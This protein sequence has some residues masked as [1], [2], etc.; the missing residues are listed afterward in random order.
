V[1]INFL[2]PL[3]STSFQSLL[4]LSFL[5]GAKHGFDADH[6]VAID[7]LTRIQSSANRRNCGALFSLGHGLVVLFAAFVLAA[8][9]AVWV[10]PQWL[11]GWALVVSTSLLIMLGGLNVWMLFSTPVD[12]PVSL[13]S[14]RLWAVGQFR[15]AAKLGPVAIGALMALSFDTLT[16]ALIFASNPAESPLLG[17]VLLGA[18]FTLG[19]TSSDGINGLLMARL[20]QRADTAAIAAS[21]LICAA[22]AL[23]CFLVGG[24]GLIRLMSIDGF[25]HLEEITSAYPWLLSTGVCAV[26]LLAYIAGL[27]KAKSPSRTVQ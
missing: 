4:L 11:S 15:F 20:M 6:L 25:S 24:L 3:N 18:V 9:G 27:R 2:S 5:L 10:V 12:K 8:L 1:D 22:I 13:P 26:I 7:S 17:A 19:M 14:L 21:R 16:Q 23:T